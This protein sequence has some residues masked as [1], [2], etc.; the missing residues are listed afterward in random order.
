MKKV[1]SVAL[2]RQAVRRVVIVDQ[3]GSLGDRGGDEGGGGE[4][5][6]IQMGGL[7]LGAKITR[8]LA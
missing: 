6:Q 2:F 1:K 5:Q 3:R 8:E 7:L 4:E